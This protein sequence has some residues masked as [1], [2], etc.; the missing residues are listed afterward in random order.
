MFIVIFPLY[1]TKLLFFSLMYIGIPL[2]DKMQ[3]FSS[4]DKYATEKTAE[5]GRKA[6]DCCSLTL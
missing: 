3:T 4:R 2:K 6:Q 5:A 1:L